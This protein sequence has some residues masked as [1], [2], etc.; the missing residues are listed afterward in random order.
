MTPDILTTTQAADYLG[1]SPVSIRHAIHRGRISAT[2]WGRDWQIRRE[3]LDTY[4]RTN[5]RRKAT[6]EHDAT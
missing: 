1:L 2:R 5:Y 4:R 3:D 6:E